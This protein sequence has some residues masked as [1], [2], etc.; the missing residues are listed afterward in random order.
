MLMRTDPFRELDRLAQQFLG[1]TGTSARPA[2]MPMDAYRSGDD[3]VVQLDL[4]GVSPDSIDLDVERNVLTVKAE[5]KAEFGDDADVQIAER[6]RGVFS[7]ELFLGDTLD[8]DNIKADY[9]AGVLTIRVPTAKQ[10]KPHK[11]AISGGDDRKKL[12]A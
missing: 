5:R 8:T 4:P 2:A 3:Y 9:D 1:Y 7:R 10:A 12:N 6:P 11:I